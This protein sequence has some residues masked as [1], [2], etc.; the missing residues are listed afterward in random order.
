M[1]NAGI[2]AAYARMNT[3]FLFR[4][5]LNLAIWNSR[6]ETRGIGE[7]KFRHAPLWLGCKHYF[8][9]D[10]TSTRECHVPI[11]SC[12]TQLSAYYI[13]IFMMRYNQPLLEELTVY[14]QFAAVNIFSSFNFSDRNYSIQ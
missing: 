11:E 14:V 7:S 12:V 6:F 8:S 3:L 13:C 10:D 2:P 1:I 9:I 4:N 5:T